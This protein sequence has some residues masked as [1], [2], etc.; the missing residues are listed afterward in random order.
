MAKSTTAV[1]P[2]DMMPAGSRQSRAV[3]I[4]KTL[5]MISRMMADVF[6][7]FPIHRA[8]PNLLGGR[9]H[10]IRAERT[11]AG[12][13]QM[14]RPVDELQSVQPHPQSLCAFGVD[15]PIHMRVWLE[16]MQQ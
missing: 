4:L 7:K 8:R 2:R 11:C 15:H 13:G 9:A 5:G 6:R 16:S 1:I 12:A 14:N 10:G 3:P